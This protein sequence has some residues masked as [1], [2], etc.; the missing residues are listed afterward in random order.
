MT[1]S[2]DQPTPPVASPTPEITRATLQS[3]EPPTGWWGRKYRKLESWLSELSTKSNFWHR[4][5]AWKFLPLAYESGIK[6]GKQ[7]GDTYEVWMPFKAFNKNW[8]EAMAGAALLANSE[9]AGGMFIFEKVGA[10]YTVVCKELH[11]KFRRPCHG[12]AIYRV[13]PR[14]DVDALRKAQLEFNVT[15]DLEILQAIVRKGDKERK[16]GECVA[17]FHVAPKAMMRARRAK[18][19][20]KREKKAAGQ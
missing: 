20:G 13:K 1:T 6:L 11:Y 8:Y 3:H 9:V 10:D 18:D 7:K 4:V 17:T 15:T 5:F 2:P 14:E 19:K 16:V 12:P